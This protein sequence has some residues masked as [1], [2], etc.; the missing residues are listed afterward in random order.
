MSQS[1]ELIFATDRCAVLPSEIPLRIMELCGAKK[2]DCATRTLEPQRWWDYVQR[3]RID[4][5][6][7]YPRYEVVM[8]DNLA[9]S[10]DTHVSHSYFS[11][12]YG[13]SELAASIHAAVTRDIPE[14]IRGDFVP[15][16]LYAGV[17]EHD[18][19]ESSEN[20]E[21]LYLLRANFSVRLFGYST[22][23]NWRKAREAILDLPEVKQA[24]ALLSEVFGELKTYMIWHA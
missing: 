15:G 8:P 10:I 11:I 12:E 20:D 21:G 23:R 22:P 24:H 3:C 17:G 19:F 13:D 14:E 18:V 2:I 5:D 9:R 4:P 7:D 6:Q 16:M 1:G